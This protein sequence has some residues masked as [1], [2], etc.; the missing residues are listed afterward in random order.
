M[1]HP[2]VRCTHIVYINGKNVY[3]ISYW[4]IVIYGYLGL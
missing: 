4:E 2:H 3:S 1:L